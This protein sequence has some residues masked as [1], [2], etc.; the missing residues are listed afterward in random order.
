[1]IRSIL[2]FFKKEMVLT[3]AIILTFITCIVIPIDIKYLDYFDYGTLILLFCILLV[4]SGLKS[5]NFLNWI[6]KK[7]IGLFKTRRGIAFALVFGTLIIDM[8]V[9]NDM[10]LITF[11]PLSYITLHTT[12]NDEYIPY[13][14]VLQTI[15]ANMGGMITPYGNPQN[16]YLYNYFNLSA[17]EIFQ[18]LLTQ[19]LV[20]IALL[21]IS[22]L[23]IKND[24]LTIKEKCDTK[25]N[26][27][28]FAL[29]F[30]LFILVIL[31]IFRVINLYI[32]IPLIVIPV[33]IVDRRRFKDIDYSL[34]A[35]FV[36]FFI[37]SGNLSRINSITKVITGVLKK[38]T[39][40]A[41]LLSC[42]IISNVP[43]AI[44]LSKFT[45]DVTSI[46]ISVNVGSLGI[47]ISSLASLIGLKEYIKHH[48]KGVFKYIIIHT[49]I[50]FS[51]LFI[52]LLLT[53]FKYN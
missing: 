18:T 31:G 4:V 35:T 37:F 48:K 15:A 44:L 21:V 1:M 46:L 36:V 2:D 40:F 30:F 49:A 26:K 3:I 22:L 12:Q 27:K 17:I 41:G 14:F 6:S 53:F 45:S 32:L 50:N 23:F 47:I 10:S 7:I 28:Y 33:L 8:I 29:Y 5:T 20:I 24:P 16:L 13:I 42:Q 19:Y 38:N 25:I 9:A 43:T 51:F 11:L 34:L 39:L 52:I